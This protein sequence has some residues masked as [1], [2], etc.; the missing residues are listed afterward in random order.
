MQIELSIHGLRKMRQPISQPVG[1]LIFEALAAR[2][3]S[4]G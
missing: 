2:K 4:G 1:S 3:I